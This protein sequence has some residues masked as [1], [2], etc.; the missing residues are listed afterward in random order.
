MPPEGEPLPVPRLFSV[1]VYASSGGVALRAPVHP[2]LGGALPTLVLLHVLAAFFFVLVHGPSVYAMWQLRRERDP[3][4]A[5]ALLDLSSAATGATWNAFGALALTG[6]LVALAEHTWRLRW[7]WGS[8]VLFV[9][10]SVS[11]SLLGARPMNHA[12]GA[13]GRKWFDGKRTQPETGIVDAPAFE[14]A[15]AMI[16]ARAPYVMIIGVGGLAGLVWLMVARPG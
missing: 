10:V 7:V 8:A 9:A 4:R 13:L 15:T 2:Y 14:R 11:M 5:G 16:L 6:I 1:R 3:V 12:R